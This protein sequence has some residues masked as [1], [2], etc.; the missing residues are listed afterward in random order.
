MTLAEL[1]DIRPTATFE[2]G[3][4]G[5]VR[6]LPRK[7]SRCDRKTRPGYRMCAH[8]QELA[9]KA[10]ERYH[11]RL[12]RSQGRADVARRSCSICGAPGVT[13]QSHGQPGHDRHRAQQLCS[14]CGGEIS[15]SHLRRVDEYGNVT[16]RLHD[17]CALHK[18][19]SSKG[20]ARCADID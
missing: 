14:L 17:E 13:S 20:L 11:E 19:L 9:R 6:E 12:R 8:H 15:G 2:I 4:Q 18:L 16:A 10:S 5:E 3:A 7:C 1:R